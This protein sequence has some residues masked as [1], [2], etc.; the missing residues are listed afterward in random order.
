VSSRR[1]SDHDV[2]DVRW[3]PGVNPSLVRRIYETDELGVV[4]DAAGIIVHEPILRSMRL[5]HVP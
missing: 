5:R 2:D 1:T 3:D 4:D